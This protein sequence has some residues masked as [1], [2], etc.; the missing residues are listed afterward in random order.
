MS[1][2]PSAGFTLTRAEEGDG[3]DCLVAEVLR[4]LSLTPR[5]LPGRLARLSGRREPH[6]A[7]A[8]L[9]AHL[10]EVAGRLAPRTVID[11]APGRPARTRRLLDALG[12]ASTYVP[13]AAAE[14]ALTSTA[15]AL[16][17]ERPWLRV[18]AV[19]RDPLHGLGPLPAPAPRLFVVPGS[20]V[21]SL[22]PAERAAFLIALRTLLGPQDAVLLG[23]ELVREGAG[24]AEPPGDEPRAAAALHGELLALLNRK[25]DADFAPDAFTHAVSWNPRLLRTELRLRARHPVAVRIPKAGLTVRFVPGEDVLTDIAARLRPPQLSDVLA[26]AWLAPV[27][28]W[29]DASGRHA[30]TL[31]TPEAA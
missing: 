21:G 22:W 12:T 13:V 2:P 31:A 11:L 16:A 10:D 8:L 23:T 18:R 15:R 6:A 17:G 4:G 30:L 19:L 9:A 26:G 29:I 27:R 3:V 28:T 25:L 5:R 14:A 1:A 20:T 24:R 7:D